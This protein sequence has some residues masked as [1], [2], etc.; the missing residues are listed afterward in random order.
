MFSGL[1]QVRA[2]VRQTG[3]ECRT[4]RGRVWINRVGSW[5]P[6]YGQVQELGW[7]VTGTLNSSG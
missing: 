4:F 7:E 6:A 3:V 5:D 1:R 2:A